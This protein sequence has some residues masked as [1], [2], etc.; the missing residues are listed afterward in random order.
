MWPERPLNASSSGLILC[1]MYAGLNITETDWQHSPPAV[2]NE[3]LSLSHQMRLLQLRCAA[4]EQRIKELGT[5]FAK[6]AELEAQVAALTERVRQN[7]RN[8]SK[9]PSSDGPVKRPRS[10]REPSGKKTGGQ[11][12]HAGHWRKLQPPAAVDHFV[13]LRPSHC[14]QCRSTLSGDDPQPQRHQVSEVPPAK[15]IVSEYRRHTLRC[16]NCGAATQADWP[17]EMP[18]GGFGPRAEAI[19]AFLT[20]RLGC[21]HRDV[22][23]AMETLHGLK[24]GLGS[25]AAIDQRISIALAEP[26]KAAQQYVTQQPSHHVDETAW[27]EENKRAWL[28]VHATAAVT[29]FRLLSKRGKEQAQAVVGEQFK[30]VVNTDRY[31]AYHWIDPYQRQLC[32]AHLRR[33][34]QAISERQGESAEIGQKLLAQTKELFRLT[35]ELHTDKLSWS[36]F[37]Q[38]MEPVK[39]EVTQLLQAGKNCGHP[40]TESTCR[41]LL[42]LGCSL[43][44]FTRVPGIAAE[45]NA[46]ERPLRRAVLWRRKSFG[47]QSKTGSEFVERILTTVTTLRQQE[48]DVLEYLKAACARSINNDSLACLLPAPP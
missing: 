43:W 5:K 41:N 45:N 10:S 2:R 6:V 32:W 47:T 3:L 27:R 46:A 30:G 25:V 40:K 33:D 22:V 11:P 8:S 4:Y 12:G 42:S 19:I 35:R 38:A 48:R 9:P 18:R 15:A 17:A 26:V 39:T 1:A 21:S 37:R 14:A 24:L 13:E 16:A 7:S 44:T 34:F 29:V 36:A 20:G 23:E 31:N 28:W